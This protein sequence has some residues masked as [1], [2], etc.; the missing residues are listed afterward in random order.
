MFIHHSL[1]DRLRSLV[2]TEVSEDSVSVWK[3]GRRTFARDDIAVL[4]YQFSS[5]FS[6]VEEFLEARIA[7]RL[8]AFEQSDRA[9]NHRSG[10][11]RTNAFAR[12]GVPN[13]QFAQ[14]L[15]LIQ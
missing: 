11:Y 7:R 13:K 10:T 2:S 6:T 14:S 15:V 12:F 5:V 8:L 1:H 9:E 4:G 3:S